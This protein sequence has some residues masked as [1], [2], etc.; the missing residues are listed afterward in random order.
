MR[1]VLAFPVVVVAF[2]VDLLRRLPGAARAARITGWIAAGLILVAGVIAFLWMAQRAPQRISLADLAAGNLSPMQ[3]WIIVSGEVAAQ[4]ATD[5]TWYRYRLSDPGAPM[6]S[7]LIRSPVELA[8][9]QTTVSGILEG[10]REP[11]PAGYRWVGQLGGDPQ[12]AQEPPPPWAAAILALA[13]LII[14]LA[15]RTSYPVFFR[16]SPRPARPTPG[17]TRVTVWRL[18]DGRYAPAIQANLEIDFGM[19]PGVALM[20]G[21]TELATL[22]LHSALTSAQVGL[23]RSLGRSEPVLW[24]R[25]SADDLMISFRSRK[26]R[27]TAYAALTAEARRAGRT[28]RR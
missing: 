4:P 6:A 17:L 8:L 28:R 12:L 2:V 3:S 16:E 5:T 23:L 10:G 24:V 27:D 20:S 1:D 21:G 22:R 25:A 18:S 9:G 14:L 11:V 15:R 13:A 7:L 26:E 19:G